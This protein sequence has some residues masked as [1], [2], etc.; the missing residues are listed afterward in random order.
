[1]Y[2]HFASKQAILE[3]LCQRGIDTMLAG[4]REA[5][6][7]DDPAAALPALVRLHADFAVDRRA[8]IGV[9]A[10]EQR[11]LPEPARR[12]LRRRQREYELVWRRVVGARRTDLTEAEVSAAVT[13]ALSLLNAAALV[14]RAVP[15]DALRRLLARMALAALR[16]R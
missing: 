2:R 4:A 6:G 1:M 14:E 12:A 13:A 3:A 11:A 16:A 15:E 8:L 9:W 7:G 10:R 5:A